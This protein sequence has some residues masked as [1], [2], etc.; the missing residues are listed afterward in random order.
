VRARSVLTAVIG[1]ALA[2]APGAPAAFP[3]KN[4]LIAFVQIKH[5]SPDIWVVGPKG[6][7][8]KDL[9]RTRRFAEF[10]PSF[11]PD[12]RTI[13]FLW[14]N[15][16][17]I[18]QGIGIVGANGKGLRHLTTGNGTS[19]FYEHP[20]WSAD[21]KSILY[22]RGH[23]DSNGEP[24]WEIWSIPAHG[25]AQQRLLSDGGPRLSVTSPIGSQLAYLVIDPLGQGEDVLETSDFSGANPVRVGG[26]APVSDW[27]PDGKRFVYIAHLAVTTRAADGSG[28]PTLVARGPR[29][30]EDP[31]YS[32]DGRFVIWSNEATHDLWIANAGGG[33]AHIFTHQPGFAKEPTWG[34][35]RH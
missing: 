14:T 22:T 21:G 27:S 1:G 7:K 31:S 2:A 29:R 26:Q 30:D 28:N 8:G 18:Q 9:T 23:N 5:F 24:V 25:G 34:P 11:S 3:G 4:G 16:T 35:A 10:S 32:P 20:S 12:G 33:G 17:G 6:G 15:R 19:D 13:A